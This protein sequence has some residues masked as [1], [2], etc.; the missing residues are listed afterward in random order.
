M[1][2]TVEMSLYP[3]EADFKTTIKAFIAS[4]K[5]YEGISVVS[6]N[7][8]TQFSGDY[9]KVMSLLN[10][11]IKKMLETHTSLFV[12]KILAGDKINR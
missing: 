8:S 10:N 4:L 9:D 11:E 5:E 12:M 6:N 3:L 7:I 2:I 1:K